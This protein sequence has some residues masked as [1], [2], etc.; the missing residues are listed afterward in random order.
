MD[1]TAASSRGV[2]RAPQPQRG[3]RAP[4]FLTMNVGAKSFEKQ[5][6]DKVQTDLIALALGFKDLGV[7]LLGFQECGKAGALVV[8]GALGP[9]YDHFSA[10]SPDPVSTFWDTRRY[11]KVGESECRLLFPDA[12]DNQND[13][14]ARRKDFRT[15][16]HTFLTRTGPRPSAGPEHFVFS[17]MHIVQTVVGTILLSSTKPLQF[18]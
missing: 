11:T 1:P 16:T 7:P 5:Y 9:H 13:P 18:V 2:G 14:R 15:C 8:V 10:G 17:S 3:A 12:V 6:S 4:D